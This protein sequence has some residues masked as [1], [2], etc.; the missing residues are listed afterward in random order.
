MEPEIRRGAPFAE[1]L[2]QALAEAGVPEKARRYG[3][4]WV[5]K[6]SRFLGTKKF[7]EAGREAVEAFYR[8]LADAEFDGW[9]IYG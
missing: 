7:Y 6:L 9:V 2:E 5:M 4:A 8:Q 3:L 1:R